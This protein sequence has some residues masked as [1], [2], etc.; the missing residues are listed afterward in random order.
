MPE[1]NGGK[2]DCFRVHEKYMPEGGIKR[3]ISGI[4]SNKCI[5]QH[6]DKQEGDVAVEVIV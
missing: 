5:K 1:N 2:L 3:I 6:Y 4:Q